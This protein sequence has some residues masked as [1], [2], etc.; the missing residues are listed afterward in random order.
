[1]GLGKEV[2]TPLLGKVKRLRLESRPAF[3]ATKEA[4]DMPGKRPPKANGLGKLRGENRDS[5]TEGGG[6]GKGG[7]NGGLDLV[8]MSRVN[9]GYKKGR[10]GSISGVIS[11]FSRSLER[12]ALAE[13]WSLLEWWSLLFASREETEKMLGFLGRVLEAALTLEI[14][15]G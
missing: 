11:S 13:E 3:M 10:I 7:G 9:P 12:L 4:G 14:L 15:V 1:M 5:G 2:E 8:N 6:A